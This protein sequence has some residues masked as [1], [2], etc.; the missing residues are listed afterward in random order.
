MALCFVFYMQLTR[1]MPGEDLLASLFYTALTVWIVLSAFMPFYWVPPTGWDMLLFASIG[2]LGFLGLLGF[3]KAAEIAPT[4]VSAPVG[5]IQPVLVVLGD[6]A[7]RG[8]YPGRLSLA[9]AGLVIVYLG[10][11]F[12]Q[13]S[14]SHAIPGY[15]HA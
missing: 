4:W 7:V 1:A 9:A 12:Y 13:N 14:I 11:L 6:W 15:Q 5:F 8:I 2:L 10:F 3:D